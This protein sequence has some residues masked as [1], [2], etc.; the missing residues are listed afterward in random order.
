VAAG[1]GNWGGR[2]RR[3]RRRRPLP[4]VIV[5]VVLA[6]I[7]GFVWIKVLGSASSSGRAISCN[8]PSAPPPTVAGQPP[9]T[10]G[11]S[12]DPEALDRTV[13][14][15][16][17]QVLVKVMNASTQRGRAGEVTE[18]LRQ[19]GFA[20]VAAPDND[21]LYLAAKNSGAELSCRAQIRYGPQGA[22]AARTLSLVEPCAQLVK[23]NRQDPT[24]DLAL[25]KAFDNLRPKPEARRVLEQVSQWSI[26]HPEAQGGLQGNPQAAPQLDPEQ[27]HTARDVRC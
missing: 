5:L 2:S 19:L 12:Q 24:V 18:G 11:Q 20:Q 10:L 3:Y 22:A 9:T 8:A 6:V 1:S 15:A 4:A 26:E 27:L 21:P 17:G 14:V 7:T 16:P 25:G 23:D 13:P